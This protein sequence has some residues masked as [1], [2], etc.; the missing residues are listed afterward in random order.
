MA[1][2]HRPE[3]LLDALFDRPGPRVDPWALT[4]VA[5]ARYPQLAAQ[6]PVQVVK[7]LLGDAIL[8]QEGYPEVLAKPVLADQLLRPPDHL[9]DGA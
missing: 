7:E 9:E 8:A 3:H 1:L 4:K 6:Q 2:L 5:P